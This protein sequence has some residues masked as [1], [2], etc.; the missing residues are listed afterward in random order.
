MPRELQPELHDIF[1]ITEDG[2]VGKMFDSSIG[3]NVYRP[4]ECDYTSQLPDNPTRDGILK[5]HC[6][7]NF[8]LYPNS[9]DTLILCIADDLAAASSR[10]ET[11]LQGKRPSPRYEVYK[12]WNPLKSVKEAKLEGKSGINEV[13][14]YLKTDPSGQDFLKQYQQMLTLRSEDANAERS[15]TTLYTHLKLSGQFYR[16]LKDVTKFPIL[17]KDL[18]LKSKKEIRLIINRYE[19]HSWK[20][21]TVRCKLHISQNPIRAKDLNIYHML[22]EYIEKI[23]ESFS[24]NILLYTSNELLLVV[25]DVEVFKEKLKELALSNFWFEIYWSSNEL[26]KLQ[27]SPKA[28]S[29]HFYIMELLEYLTPPLCEI[30]QMSQGIARKSEEDNP[31]EYLCDYCFKIR[32]YGTLMG[33]FAY[34]SDKGSTRALWIKLSLDIDKLTWVLNDLYFDYLK[35]LDDSITPEKAQIRFSVIAEFQQDYDLFIKELK[36]L[37]YESYREND[38]QPILKDF[39][40]V[41]IESPKQIINLLNIFHSLII[42]YFPM[43]IKSNDSPIKIGLVCSP[44][45]YP[46]F[47]VWRILEEPKADIHVGLIGQGE[48]RVQ[49]NQLQKLLEAANGQYRKSSLHKLAEVARISES[50]AK[51]AFGDSSERNDFQTYEALKKTLPLGLGFRDMLTFAKIIGD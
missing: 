14:S 28:N 6:S 3:R 48:L 26:N 42:K 34:W 29:E 51:L 44:I 2:H 50:L 27:L 30:C 37:L 17:E 38:I 49:M 15:I 8:E 18:N 40:T 13:L 5:H 45:K 46:F 24:D 7:E 12:L 1:K 4:S 41:H 36:R 11:R 39:Y 32:E 21:T 23:Y 31:I 47:E 43:F 19:Q 25:S 10:S 20:I 22:N 33:K 35:Q 16:I 9:N